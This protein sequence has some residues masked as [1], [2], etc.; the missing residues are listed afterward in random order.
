VSTEQMWNTLRADFPQTYQLFTNLKL[1]SDGWAQVPG[2]EGFTRFDGTPSRSA[3]VI[4]DNFRDDVIPALERQQNNY[5]IT[6]TNWPRLTV[7][8]PLLTAV[9]VLV[10]VY[11]VLLGVLTRRQARR[12]SDEETPPTP[13]PIPEPVHSN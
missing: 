3:P 8:A 9:G 1:V 4:R 5:V 7:F 6:D 11:G 2:T 12:Q 10:I 13:A